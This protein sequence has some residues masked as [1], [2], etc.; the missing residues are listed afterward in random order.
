[1]A[2]QKQYW[3]NK[4]VLKRRHPS[5][6]AVQAFAGPKVDL[7]VEHIGNHMPVDHNRNTTLLDVGSGNGYVSYYLDRHF[8]VTCLDFSHNMLKLCPLDK[9]ILASAT[10]LPLKDESFD[11]VF[12]SNLLHH[13]KNPLEVLMEMSRVSS[14]YL[15]IVEP[16]RANP[17]MFAFSFVSI[18]DK[19]LRK[20]S[21]K[22]LGSLCDKLTE[23]KMVFAATTGFVLPNI[24]P[25]F[26]LPLMKK[27]ES[28]LCPKLF[29]LLI[30]EKNA[31]PKT[32]DPADKAE[33]TH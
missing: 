26:L 10:H 16:N 21:A 22:Y 20:F 30:L 33:K 31:I 17:L 6:P 5:H 19:G 7:I 9:N 28:C 2:F 8:D 29:H 23:Y 1:M 13:L 15:I 27:L 25:T 3:E 12:C 24:T 18:A 32:M 14:R 11:I 4:K